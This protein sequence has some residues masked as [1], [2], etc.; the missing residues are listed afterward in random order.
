MFIF[1][2]GFI[3]SLS[4]RSQ[5]SVMN[6]NLIF[7][8][9][10][11][12]LPD[13]TQL[14]LLNYFEAEGGWESWKCGWDRKRCEKINLAARAGNQRRRQ[15]KRRI[16]LGRTNKTATRPG[17]QQVLLCLSPWFCLWTVMSSPLI[18]YT[19]FSF[20]SHLWELV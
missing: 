18:S 20:L 11:Q 13:N 17:C 2:R 5:T 1:V 6:Y 4:C 10:K 3:P 15:K 12:L 7:S 19:R 14:R 9:V 8:E 16:Q